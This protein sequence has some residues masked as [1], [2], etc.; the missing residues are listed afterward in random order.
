MSKR[1]VRRVF[2]DEFRIEAVKLILN[3]GYTIREASN[4]L[5]VSTASLTKWKKKY[6]DGGVS[7]TSG[8][9]FKALQ[10]ELAK[11]KMERDILKKALGYFAE[12]QK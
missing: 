8:R 6:S 1:K 7:V 2:S 5:G 11:T 9:D 12:N 3:E 10:K 4:K